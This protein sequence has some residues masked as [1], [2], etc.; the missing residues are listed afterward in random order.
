[1]SDFEATI[2]HEVGH[3]VA[4][5]MASTQQ[6]VLVTEAMDTLGNVQAQM[7]MSMYGASH[8]HEFIA[9][10]FVEVMAKGADAHPALVTLVRKVIDFDLLEYD[11]T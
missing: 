3:V 2:I 5:R 9:E 8:P 10:A 11:E 4:K 6:N 7:N 1:M